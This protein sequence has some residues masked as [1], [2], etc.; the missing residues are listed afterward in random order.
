L[1]DIVCFILDCFVVFSNNFKFLLFYRPVVSKSLVA[2]RSSRR[3]PPRGTSS[4]AADNVA[5]KSKL[6]SLK[7]RLESSTKIHGAGTSPLVETGSQISAEGGSDEVVFKDDVVPSNPTS[8][9]VP[10]GKESAHDDPVEVSFATGSQ[11]ST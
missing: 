4:G 6:Y 11:I 5:V 7:D 2:I 9:T 10:T 3:R 8:E 1:H